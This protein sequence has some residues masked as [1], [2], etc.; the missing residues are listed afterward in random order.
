MHATA[1]PR[2]EK[3]G[4]AHPRKGNHPNYPTGGDGRSKAATITSCGSHHAAALVRKLPTQSAA[5]RPSV[6]MGSRC[7]AACAAARARFLNRRAWQVPVRTEHA[8]I[9][10]LWLQQSLTLMTFVEIMTGVRWHRFGR[11][12]PADWTSERGD[13]FQ[14]EHGLLSSLERKDIPRLLWRGRAQGSLPWRRH[15]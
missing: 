15:K 8:T 13:H 6:D 14:R 5:D 1:A 12:M 11:M 4:S 9:P 2:I 3:A 7:A 10:R